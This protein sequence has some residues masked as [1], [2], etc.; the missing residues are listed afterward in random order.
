MF[1]ELINTEAVGYSDILFIWKGLCTSVEGLLTE[2]TGATATGVGK[3]VTLVL[4]VAMSD[5]SL[6]LE[7]VLVDLFTRL[8]HFVSRHMHSRLT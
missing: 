7:P 5:C 2:K 6:E 4:G 8:L 3:L 1:G